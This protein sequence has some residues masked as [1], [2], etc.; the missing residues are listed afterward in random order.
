MTFLRIH[1]IEFIADEASAQ[2]LGEIMRQH[3]ES[4][5]PDFETYK[6]EEMAK[7]NNPVI[8]VNGNVAMMCVSDFNDTAAQIMSKY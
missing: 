5:K 4:R 2:V 8:V 1:P 6:P 7:L 3:V